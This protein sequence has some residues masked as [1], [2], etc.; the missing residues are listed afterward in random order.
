MPLGLTVREARDLGPRLI[1]V[2]SLLPVRDGIA[3]TVFQG[4]AEHILVEQSPKGV[5]AAEQV[6]AESIGS[7]EAKAEDPA[8]E[9][10]VRRT[11][12]ANHF[13]P[14]GHP[15]MQQQVPPLV[16]RGRKRP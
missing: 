3:D 10:V 11:M 2:G 16:P 8:E 6:E 13:L 7:S 4:H 15:T 1:R 5:W 14:I 12:T 9:M